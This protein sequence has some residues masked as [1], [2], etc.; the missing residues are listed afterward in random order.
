M[1]VNVTKKKKNANVS[2]TVIVKK[3]AAVAKDV[4]VRNRWVKNAI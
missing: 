1:S 2:V 3:S 4:V